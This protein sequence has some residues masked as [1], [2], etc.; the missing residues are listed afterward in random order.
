MYM[1]EQL[2]ELGFDCSGFVYY[3]YN[4]VGYSL[5]RTCS[6]QAKSGVSVAKADLQ[7]GDLVF[8]NNTSDGSIGH[9]GIYVGSGNFIHAAN[10]TRG[11]VI[12]TINSGYYYTYYY[13][14]RRII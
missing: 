1:Q 11:V 13:S 8:F 6:S 12:D 10:T 14:A 5:A 4:S 2:Q 9:V 7:P 3:V